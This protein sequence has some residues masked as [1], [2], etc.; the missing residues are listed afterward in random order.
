MQ[1]VLVADGTVSEASARGPA[2]AAANDPLFG[3]QWGL[4]ATEA[5]AAWRVPAATQRVVVA[6]VDSGVDASQPDLQGRV[7]PG[8]NVIDGNANTSDDNGHGTAVA[9]IIAAIT[10]NGIGVASYCPRCLILPVKVL[11]AHAYGNTSDVAKG[12]VWAV[13]HGARVINVSISTLVDA[14][15]LRLAVS[16]A[17]AHGALVVASAGNFGGDARNFPAA[18]PGALA[19]AAA[20]EN[21]KLF[22]W[23]ASGSWVQL[24]APGSNLTTGLDGYVVLVGTSAAA[25]VV[26]GI[27]ALALSVAPRESLDD[28]VA[29]LEHGAVALAGVAYGEV[30]AARTIAAV[31]PARRRAAQASFLPSCGYGSARTAHDVRPCP[32]RLTTSRRRNG[33]ERVRTGL[34]GRDRSRGARAQQALVG[35][36]RVGP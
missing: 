4:Q 29:A 26:S 33:D 24:A 7:Q 19:V 10:G 31:M 12:I 18:D 23:S 28:L 34:P 32:R 27:A 15:D 1:A 13:D 8:W 5:P 21:R 17:V 30:D 6:V 11:N 22:D 16:Y 25:P 3:E 36:R 2:A 35:R 20:D 14:P 9:G